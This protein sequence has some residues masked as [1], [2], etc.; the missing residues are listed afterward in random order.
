MGYDEHLKRFINETI[1][2]EHKI[3]RNNMLLEDQYFV[4]N[5]N[6]IYKIRLLFLKT[7]KQSF[8]KI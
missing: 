5:L 3:A 7:M 8:N 6:I 2:Y 4:Y 1:K